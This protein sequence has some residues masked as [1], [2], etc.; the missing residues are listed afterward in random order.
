MTITKTDLI[1]ALEESRTFEGAVIQG[2]YDLERAAQLLDAKADGR[3][4]AVWFGLGGEEE[5][6]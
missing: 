6:F 1:E 5:A 3:P 4:D 2:E